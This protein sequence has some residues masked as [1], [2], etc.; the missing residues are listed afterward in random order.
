MAD[1]LHVDVRLDAGPAADAEELDELTTLL[2]RQ[3]LESGVEAVDRIHD[4]EA[5]AGT[6][7]VDPVVLGGLL[8]T[9]V[10]STGA[11]KMLTG[12]L[13]AW[14]AGRAGRSVELQIGGDTLKV[15]GI[16]SDQ[17]QHLIALFAQRHCE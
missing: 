11:L 5:P 14:V 8:I 1:L 2:R 17:Q 13:Q 7:A 12:A 16:S 15:T 6:R 4:G 3:L 9:V 10:K